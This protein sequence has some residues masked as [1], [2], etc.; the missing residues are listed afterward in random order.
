VLAIVTVPESQTGMTANLQGPLLLNRRARLGRQ[1]ISADPRW[2]VRHAILE[3]IALARQ[4]A[5]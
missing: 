3:E 2:G 1:S 4:G 5:C